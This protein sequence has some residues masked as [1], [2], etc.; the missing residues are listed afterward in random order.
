MK[1]SAFIIL[2]VLLTPARAAEDCN[3]V[4]VKAIVT[5]YCPCEICC[6]KE[7]NHSAYKITTSGHKIKDGDAFCAAPPEIPFGTLIAIE[8]YGVVPVLDRGG[9]IK[10]IKIDLFFD[11]HEE[12]LD[13]GRREMT[14][15][16]EIR[17]E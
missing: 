2:F 12:A 7:P 9:A 4:P 14:I 10:G 5:A 16:V 3:F 1:L 13:W 15:L 11:T 17:K 8:G 6:G